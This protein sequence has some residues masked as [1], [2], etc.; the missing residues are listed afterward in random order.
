MP[1]YETTENVTIISLTFTL[2]DQLTQINKIVCA[3]LSA[4]EVMIKT[5]QRYVGLIAGDVSRVQLTS[6]GTMIHCYINFYRNV[7][8]ERYFFIN[9]PIILILYNMYG[10]K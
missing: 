10:K 3:N 6:I 9:R 2:Y 8:I 4:R 7:K 5:F 1:F